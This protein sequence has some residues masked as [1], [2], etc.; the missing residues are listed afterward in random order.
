MASED[1]CGG[2]C[3]WNIFK[4]PNIWLAAVLLGRD[5]TMCLPLYKYCTWSSYHFTPI[6]RGHTQSVSVFQ[7]RLCCVSRAYLHARV[8]A[9][10]RTA[11]TF[12]QP[13]HS[14]FTPGRT[15][16]LPPSEMS[17]G[18]RPLVLLFP[19]LHCL[20]RWKLYPFAHVIFSS[21]ASVKQYLRMLTWLRRLTLLQSAFQPLERITG[22][23]YSSLLELCCVC[24]LFV[25]T[26]YHNNLVINAN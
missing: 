20:I 26:N 2:G 10:M 17:R 1:G 21:S 8:C 3:C 25:N 16:Y 15:I 13:S 14:N 6:S 22:A 24:R 5:R 23:W 19:P 18:N 9:V 12:S 11:D 4:A 7:T